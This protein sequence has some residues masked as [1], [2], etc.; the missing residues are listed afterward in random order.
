MCALVGELDEEN[1]PL[2]KDVL[3]L[4]SDDV[5]PSITLSDS[6]ASPPHTSAPRIKSQLL[7]MTGTPL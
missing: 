1:F 5:I 6:V 3:K 2:Q 7:K 4:N